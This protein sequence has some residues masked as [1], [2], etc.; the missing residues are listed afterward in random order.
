[1]SLLVFPDKLWKIADYY[2]NRR[3]TWM[4]ARL[5]EKLEKIK[6]QE[7]ARGEFIE[8]MRRFII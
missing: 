5:E 6:S 8:D 2:Y 7:S 1:L 4:S 3:K